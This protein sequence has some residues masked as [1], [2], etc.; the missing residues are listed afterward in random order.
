MSNQTS[1]VDYIEDA[2]NRQRYCDCGRHT[3]PIY[4][5]GIIW[6]ECTSLREPPDGR[7][8][9][10]VRAVMGPLHVHEAIVEAPAA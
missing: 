10:L 2:H 3:A 6:L 5:D 8:A 7:I 9:R 1:I 4:R